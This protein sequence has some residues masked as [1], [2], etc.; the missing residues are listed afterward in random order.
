MIMKWAGKRNGSTHHHHRPDSEQLECIPFAFSSNNNVRTRAV[1]L[2]E[3][4]VDDFVSAM[5]LFAM[6]MVSRMR[7][8]FFPVPLLL[9]VDCLPGLHSLNHQHFLTIPIFHNRRKHLNKTAGGSSH[10]VDFEIIISPH[11]LT[12]SQP[13]RHA[14]SMRQEHRSPPVNRRASIPSPCHLPL[15]LLLFLASNPL[16][17]SGLAEWQKLWAAPS[18]NPGTNTSTPAPPNRQSHGMTVWKDTM[19]VHGGVGANRVGLSDLWAFDLTTHVWQN[20]SQKVTP[21]DPVYYRA[22]HSFFAREEAG[23]GEGEAPTLGLYVW[24]GR[25][26]PEGDSALGTTKAT[27][28]LLKFVMAAPMEGGG[29][30]WKEGGHWI[31]VATTSAETADPAFSAGPVGR[32][33]H[34][35]IL[36]KNP[37]TGKE[38]FLVYGGRLVEPSGVAVAA[39]SN[40]TSSRSSRSKGSGG[41][42]AR[43]VYGD[44]WSLDLETMV[45]T[46]LY[47]GGEK[48]GGPPARFLHA[49]SVLIE[50][51]G[52]EEVAK[53]VVF[54]GL[55]FFGNSLFA[56]DDVWEFS[57]KDRTWRQQK[58]EVALLRSALPMLKAPLA[59]PAAAA[60]D[61]AAAGPAAPPTSV[62]VLYAFAGYVIYTSAGLAVVYNDLLVWDP[63]KP[64]WQKFV[65]PNGKP[66]PAP[67]FDHRGV[68]W[69]KEGSNE[70][71]VLVFYGGSYQDVNDVADVWMI[72][73]GGMEEGQLTK[74]PAEGLN[75]LFAG[76][77]MFILSSLVLMCMCSAFLSL[78][79]RRQMLLRAR[80]AAGE[81]VGEGGMGQAEARGREERARVTEEALRSLPVVQYGRSDGS[82]GGE[83]GGAGAG[84]VAGAGGERGGGVDSGPA[85]MEGG[86]AERGREST[87]ADDNRDMCAIC[88]MDYVEEEMLR[89][90]PCGHRFHVQC[91]DQW[92]RSASSLSCPMCKARVTAPPSP[93]LITSPSS[94]TSSITGL[95]P[96]STATTGATTT[97]TTAHAFSSLLSSLN[98][99][100]ESRIQ[101]RVSSSTTTSTPGADH[102]NSST[103]SM[104][105][106]STAPV[107]PTSS[108]PSS[109]SAPISIAAVGAIP[110]AAAAAAEG[111]SGHATGSYQ[112]PDSLIPYH[113]MSLVE[114]Q[115]PVASSLPSSSSPSF[116]SSLPSSA[117]P[118][119]R[120]EQS[121][122]PSSSPSAAAAAAAARRNLGEEGS[123]GGGGGGGRGGPLG[124]ADLV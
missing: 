99:F 118:R 7:S 94:S 38:H 16:P 48:D 73:A 76:R 107:L 114:M 97:S 44:M 40:S 62:Q 117:S 64:F 70:G 58:M 65:N 111:E 46:L 12:S 93:S 52:G 120:Q 49:S 18:P 39:G 112:P 8:L 5:P 37:A 27:N 80:G 68:V 61:G 66:A 63:R 78:R 71:G 109:S 123:G 116:S 83:Y 51:E 69:R 115:Q 75:A 87:P 84:A 96:S 54:G 2:L 110:G 57:I 32:S 4:D 103:A 74:A 100:R 86:R 19:L 98:P 59:V 72:D 89:E 122:H 43:E 108:F 20:V 45:W 90:L 24:G 26:M 1:M 106:S 34:T 91:V 42:M 33:D 14:P 22:A 23:A 13:A 92:F 102:R 67:R 50:E 9:F 79:M 95:Y 47:A 113:D 124:G 41:Q 30:D 82:A 36:F 6:Y 17:T 11:F 60:A 10:G 56:L 81:A 31:P 85:S 15:L 25:E 21:A 3:Q 104:T 121:P 88:L 101:H 28:Q 77:M 55:T 119:R 29:E 53:I 105:D 35:G